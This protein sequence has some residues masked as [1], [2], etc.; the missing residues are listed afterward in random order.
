MAQLSLG[1]NGFCTSF[2]DQF[3]HPITAK[4]SSSGIAKIPAHPPTSCGVFQG[5][6]R[7]NSLR[8][9]PP[10]PR[11]TFRSK[12]SG[13]RLKALKK[14]VDH[15]LQTDVVFAELSRGTQPIPQDQ[16]AQVSFNCGA[17]R[18]R[19]EFTFLLLH[20]SFKNGPQNIQ[21]PIIV[22]RFPQVKYFNHRT[23]MGTFSEELGIVTFRN[24]WISSN[25]FPEPENM[26]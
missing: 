10:P 8:I 20:N 19:L 26:A 11:N 5:H 21:Q 13:N 4:S 22:R 6:Q 9:S 14:K 1:G 24:K 15:L 2:P 7:A 25:F 17:S 23:K 12:V 18:R 3:V 16:T